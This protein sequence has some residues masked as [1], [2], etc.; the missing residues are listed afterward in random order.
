[1]P[2]IELARVIDPEARALRTIMEAQDEVKQQAQAA[3]GAARFA[4]D[5]ANGYPDATF[6]L[7]LSYGTV[8]GYEEN[9]VPVS[10]TTNFAGLY[11]RS[12]DQS[13]RPPF[14]LPPR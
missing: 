3:L 8:K 6:T 10:A 13:D 14:D 1:D 7:R 4:L 11:R 2:L 12:A 5:G 9:G